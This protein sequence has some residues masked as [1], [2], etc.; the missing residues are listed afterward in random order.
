LLVEAR[1]HVGQQRALHRGDGADGDDARVG[2]MRRRLGAQVGVQP[3]QLLGLRQRVA[4]RVVQLRGAAG[5]LEQRKAQLGLQPLHL[6]ADG[7]L[8]K[9]DLVAGGGEGALA[10]HGDQGLELPNHSSILSMLETNIY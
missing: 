10:R 4:A 2:R 6:R 7:R 3:H 8:G 5:A 9:A 1:Q